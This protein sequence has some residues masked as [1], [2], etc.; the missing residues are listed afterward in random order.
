MALYLAFNLISSRGSSDEEIG[1]GIEIMVSKRHVSIVD[2]TGIW[3]KPNEI[4]IRNIE[5]IESPGADFFE[6]RGIRM[7]LLF[8]PFLQMAPRPRFLV[9]S[10]YPKK[11]IFEYLLIL[12][13]KKGVPVHRNDDDSYRIVKEL[14]EN[15]PSDSLVDRIL[16]AVKPDD[17]ERFID[18]V[19]GKKSITQRDPHQPQPSSA[20]EAQESGSISEP[21]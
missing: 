3:Q 7:P 8:R 1:R 14:S 11:T 18:L 2:R 10:F 4:E 19:M 9:G 6:S 16:I 20:P 12:H 15:D 5:D 13:L 17:Q 21:S